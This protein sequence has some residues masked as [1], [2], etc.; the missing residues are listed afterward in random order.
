MNSDELA[1]KYI[2]LT[3]LIEQEFTRNKNKYGARLKC[4]RGCSACC[5]QIFRITSFDADVI[6]NYLAKID[7]TER[8]RLQSSAKKYLDKRKNTVASEQIPCPALGNEGECTIYEAR[9]VVCRR[10]GVPIYDYKNPG[11]L[12]ACELNFKNGEEIID[13]E[14]IPKQTEIGQLWDSVKEDFGK[15][16]PTSIAEALL[17]E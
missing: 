1:P 13:E 11:K 16:E 10:F 12:H 5:S 17:Q 9:P 6:K 15:D 8:S 2:N 3:H 14:L 7:E 4:A